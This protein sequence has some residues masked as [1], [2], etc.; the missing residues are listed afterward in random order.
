MRKKSLHK[1]FQEDQRVYSMLKVYEKKVII[2]GML[3]MKIFYVNS[4]I[5]VTNKQAVTNVN[6]CNA[7]V[8]KLIPMCDAVMPIKWKMNKEIVISLK[9]RQNDCNEYKMYMHV[10]I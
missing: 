5:I 3:S 4:Y 1:I 2:E 6:Y 10:C 8:S 7:N 9:V